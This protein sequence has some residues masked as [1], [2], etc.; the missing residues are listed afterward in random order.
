MLD[1][2]LEYIT[3]CSHKPRSLSLLTFEL[4][5]TANFLTD[6]PMGGGRC[7][8]CLK[9]ESV[10]SLVKCISLRSLKDLPSCET[11]ISLI[12]F[13]RSQD[14]KFLQSA[15]ACMMAFIALSGI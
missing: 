11:S 5:N 3:H 2:H 13:A 1:G 7:V 14:Y 10:W 12:L 4:Y 6:M 15:E 8:E 9:K